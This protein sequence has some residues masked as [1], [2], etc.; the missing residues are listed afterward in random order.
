MIGRRF[1]TVPLSASRGWLIGP[2]VLAV[3]PGVLSLLVGCVTEEKIKK[4]NGYY[5]EGLS[6]LDLDRQKAFVSFQKA[7]QMNP[8]HKEAH[9]ALGHIYAIQGKLKQAEEQFREA[10]RVDP[11]YSEAHT[12]LGQVLAQQDRWNEAI[13]SYRQALSNPL[14]ATPDLARYHLGRALAH[15]GDMQAATEAFEDAL[16]VNPPSVSTA[17]IQLELGRAYY[18][19]GYDTKAREAL[20]RV[21]SLD[22]GG[23]YAAEAGKLLD[24]LR[25]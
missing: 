16:L 6:T 7:I 10:L 9:Y 3:L 23:E 15:E 20:T 12:Y 19:L 1:S 24:R 17:M 14:Y 4:A 21:T 2:C 22:K 18:R 8:Q 11:D 13:K 5:Q 25:Q